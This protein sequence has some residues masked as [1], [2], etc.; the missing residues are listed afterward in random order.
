MALHPFRKVGSGRPRATSVLIAD[1]RCLVA[2]LP[3]LPPQTSSTSAPVYVLRPVPT[4]GDPVTTTPKPLP[5][6]PD[7]W[8][9]NF[10]RVANLMILVLHDADG[11]Q[12]GIGYHPLVQPGAADRTVTALD[13]IAEPELRASA[14]K[15]INTFYERTARAQAS[16]AAFGA[17]VPDQ[18]Y[19]FDRLRSAVPGSRAE[20]GVDDEALTITL[21]LTAA[22]S[23]AGSLLTLITSWPGARD[24]PGALTVG[25]DRSF[26]DEGR[27]I[28]VLDQARA[29]R[30]LAWYRAQL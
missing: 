1:V 18:Q 5:D 12:R 24:R 20:L 10:H 3:T 22:G 21:K 19:L 23:A 27:L 2:S 16:A 17:V 26:D 15:L 14:Q 6:L 11:A 13:D 30:F 29:E 4:M 9:M 25:V 28:I 7:G 8:A